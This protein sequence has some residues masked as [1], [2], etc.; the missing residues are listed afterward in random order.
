[1]QA[2]GACWYLLGIQ[3]AAKCLKEQCME[4]KACGR[5]ALSCVEPIYYGTKTIIEDRERL[6]WASNT[7]ARATCLDSSDQ[8]SYGAYK[9]TVPLVT[10]TSRLEKI[11]LPIFWGLMTLR[12]ISSS[13]VSWSMS[14][15]HACIHA[16]FSL[17]RSTY[18][19]N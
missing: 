6:A 8:F 5:T 4:N 1:M 11:L 12:Y 16:S 10:N 18:N 13:H 3:R 7:H 19:L 14:M 9:W 15:F 2:V 17:A